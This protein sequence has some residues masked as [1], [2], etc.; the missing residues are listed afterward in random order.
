MDV[1]PAG[2]FVGPRGAVLPDM[3]AQWCRGICILRCNAACEAVSDDFPPTLALRDTA[4]LYCNRA[5]S[6]AVHRVPQFRTEWGLM[7]LVCE[8]DACVDKGIVRDIGVASTAAGGRPGGIPHEF[9]SGTQVRARLKP[10]PASC[11][12]LRW[13]AR[14]ST[15]TKGQIA[16][17]FTHSSN[18]PQD[19]GRVEEESMRPVIASKE[20]DTRVDKAIEQ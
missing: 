4:P 9:G 14:G 19:M 8:V 11:I 12:T 3:W 15:R 18:V 7:P 2:A 17:A 13:D 10:Q 16:A 20:V 6:E 1:Q 5:Y